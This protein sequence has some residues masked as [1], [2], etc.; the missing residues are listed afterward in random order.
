MRITLYKGYDK[1]AC[2]VEWSTCRT[3]G[4]WQLCSAETK[5]T[6]PCTSSS[7]QWFHHSQGLQFANGVVSLEQETLRQPR[8]VSFAASG[9]LQA[10]A[11]VE[12][13]PEHP[14]VCLARH[15]LSVLQR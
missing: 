11:I 12:L 10:R 8:T 9:P 14:S 13:K 6:R 1:V 4:G 3:L 5:V 2:A 7:K 15:V